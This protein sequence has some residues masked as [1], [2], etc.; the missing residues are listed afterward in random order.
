MNVVVD[1][2]VLVSGIFWKGSPRKF[3]SLIFRQEINPFATIDIM[4]EYC[5]II[6]KVACKRPDV[7]ARW[8]SQIAKIM[9]IIEKN[10]TVE[11][12]RDPKDNMFLECAI[13]AN[14]YYLVSGDSDLLV[15]EKIKDIPIITVNQFFDAHP[16]FDI[17]ED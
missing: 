4:A 14:A 2:N 13:A 3:L 1:A 5:R 7:A 11:V 9:T 10:E 16:E 17:V 12:C 15:L 8:K 6:D